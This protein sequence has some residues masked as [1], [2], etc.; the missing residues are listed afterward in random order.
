M[1]KLILKSIFSIFIIVLFVNVS[2]SQEW[3]KSFD[4]GSNLE[5][6]VLAATTDNQGNIYLTGYVT[7]IGSG[8]DICTRKLNA[9]G[10]E[11]WYRYY[12]G[13]GHS[14]DKAFGIAV[15]RAGGYV[16]VT[17]YSTY[18]GNNTDIT[19]IR[20]NTS[21]GVQ[22][23]INRI[24]DPS[25]LEDKAFGIVVDRFN[26]VYVTGY[27]TRPGI[28]ADIYTVKFNS[29]LVFVWHKTYV[30]NG[31]GEDKAFGI[32]TDSIGL[33]IFVTGFTTDS[34]TGTDMITISYDSS[35]TERWLKKFNGTGNNEDKAFG[36]A[37]DR[38][39]TG[40]VYVTGYVTD[41]VSGANYMTIKYKPE[42]GT[43]IWSARYNGSGN[44]Q[45]KAFGIVVDRSGNSF[46]TGMSA[47]IETGGD[48]L[49]I[50]YGFEGDT[51]WTARYYGLGGNKDSAAS[52]VLSKSFDY[53]FVSGYSINDTAVGKEDVLTIKYNTTTGDSV[54]A[55]RID[56]P[57]RMT[58]IGVV[59]VRDTSGNV[60]VGGYTYNLVTGFDWLVLKYFRGEL[61]IGIQQISSELPAGFVLYQNY[62]N[63][64]NPKTL[65]RFAVPPSGKGYEQFVQLK[66]YDILG[67]EVAAL[68]NDK[69]EPGTYVADWD[70]SKFASGIYFYTLST[71]E[72]TDTKR[73]VL[74][75]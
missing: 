69:L 75:K 65:I 50:K 63:P 38:F 12:D 1:K 20:Y 5:D 58:D 35:G 59:A 34:A 71:G 27:I 57:S 18:Q 14:E 56:M 60:F 25:N 15:D 19:T 70:A 47:G 9:A 21:T 3:I 42:N 49:T 37:V 16:Y 17:G 26:N 54:Q 73:M 11:Q 33:N 52:L 72:F 45:D 53:V 31:S 13:P 74:I 28:G 24:G 44:T 66:I 4:S 64:F 6:K 32:V 62:P 23:N 8:Q 2:L 7:R 68:V 40:G 10:Q 61:V 51:L 22:E 67:R 46:I 36:I 55:S 41:S 29:S 39:E 48:Y 43:T 30:G